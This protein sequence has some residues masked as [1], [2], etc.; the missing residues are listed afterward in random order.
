MKQIITKR[1]LSKTHP[2]LARQW[3][4][5]KNGALTPDKITATYGLNIWWRCPFDPRHEWRATVV[6]RAKRLNPTGCP[7]CG[8][9]RV[10]SAD[11]LARRNPAVAKQWDAERNG[12][13][14]PA[15]V[16]HA[17][18][19]IVWWKCPKGPDHNWQTK[20]CFRTQRIKPRGCPYCTSIRV[21]VTNSLASRYPAL[22]KEWHPHKNGARTPET[23]L[24]ASAKKA[25]WR[26]P[27]KHEWSAVIASRSRNGRGCP[28]CAGQ[29]L[30]R[31][32]SLAARFPKLAR[33]WH[34]TRNGRLTP[35]DLMSGTARQVWWK[36]A[37]GPDH[38]WQAS[39]NHRTKPLPVGCPFCAGRR[40]SVTNSLAI[41]HPEL[42]AEWH[43]R[44]N[45]P[46][47]PDQVTS[48]TS[49]KVWWRCRQRHEWLAMVD[50]RARG[51]GCPFCSGN[52]VDEKRLL[53][54]THPEFAAQWHPT[55][56]QTSLERIAFDSYKAVWWRCRKNRSHVWRATVYQRTQGEEECPECG[57]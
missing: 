27:K 50:N 14:T 26:C 23:V 44:K 49:R 19:Q 10:A 22:A 47:R 31:K 38:E 7:V 9:R 1:P 17:S 54:N 2:V 30:T 55:R 24:A 18:H 28:F 5:A 32:K 48:G 25:W 35:F 21:S 52:R 34:P 6:N 20:V 37:K 45:K 15:V 12:V 41:Q 8:K 33:Q 51:R 36:C 3:H 39:A 43:P 57:E 56:N 16:G 29:R 4:P 13:L 42:A 11:T 40:A 46:L 53:I